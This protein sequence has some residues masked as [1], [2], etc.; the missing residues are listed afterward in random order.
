MRLALQLDFVPGAGRCAHG[1][2]GTGK[3]TPRFF[4]QC[5]ASL[6]SNCVAPAESTVFTGDT[7]RT[8]DTATA[9][10]TLSGKGS[11]GIASRTQLVFTGNQQYLA[12]LKS[13][14]W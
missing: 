1:V 5:R 7:V 8:A 6:R 4:E 13:G 2:T 3:A 14:P 10:F 12:E 11:F 9:T